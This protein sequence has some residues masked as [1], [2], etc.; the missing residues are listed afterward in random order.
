MCIEVRNGKDTFFWT[1]RWLWDVLFRDRYRRLYDLSDNQLITV[2]GMCALGSGEGG[3]A[4]R[5]RR[6]LLAWEEEL[7]GECR[8][9]LHTMAL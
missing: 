1:D 6:R 8:I 4:W 2:A 3:T 7:I 5:W 9:L